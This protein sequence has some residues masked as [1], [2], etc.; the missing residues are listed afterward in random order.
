MRQRIK[1]PRALNGEVSPPGDKSISHR[2]AILNGIAVGKARV[3]NFAQS[4]DC[5]ATVSCLRALGVKIESLEGETLSIEG[6]GESGLRE[7][8]DILNAENS[9]TTMRLMAGLLASQSFLSIITGDESLR[10]RP[11]GRVIQPLRLMGAQIWGRSV[12][13][14]APLVI[15][16]GQLKGIDYTLP[17][18][19]AQLKSALLLAALFAEGDT[20]ITEP[21]PSRDHT[22]RMLK[23]MG[24]K[25]KVAGNAIGISR[26]RLK[27]IDLNVPGDLSSAAFWLVAGSIHPQAHIRIRNTGINPTRSGIVDVLR[28]MGAVLNI[29][30]EHITSGEPLAALS[31][32]SSRLHGTE[33]S[34]EIIPKVIDEIPLIALAASV[35]E[36]KTVITDAGELRVKETDRISATVKELSRLGADID[37]LP[38]GMVI[39][40][41]KKLC[42]STCDSHR[43]HRLAMMLG[44]A[45]LIAEGETLIDNAEVVNISYPKFWQD[46]ECLSKK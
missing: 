36:G 33:I 27:A 40:G 22:E 44:V 26:G 24:A 38:D 32:Q 9:A 17:V 6:V 16:G 14:R 45:A 25:I 18:A 39:R 43:D 5:F 31:V 30:D 8:E 10:S 46:L 1:A 28:N 21:S 20:V 12:D 15:K 2:A 7:A 23:A 42:G 19:S 3:S 13:S 34:G 29:E 41:V 35:A 11:M 37:E 4:A